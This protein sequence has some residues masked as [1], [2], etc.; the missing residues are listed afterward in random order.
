MKFFGQRQE[1]LRQH[2]DAAAV[3]RE[4]APRR[5]TDLPLGP[6]DVAEVEELQQRKLLG[7]EM[8]LVVE[9]LDLARG[10]MEIDEEAVIAQ[11][12]DAARDGDDILGDGTRRKIAVALLD[13]LG[14]GCPGKHARIGVAAEP[15][16]LLELLEARGAEL[17]VVAFVCHGFPSDTSLT[18]RIY[19]IPG[20]AQRV[21]R[22]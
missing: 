2:G 11:G 16:Q 17:V 1:R 12:A 15:P 3:H 8:V 22:R 13:R 18:Q 14:L 10:V 6:D 7:R 9:D 19:L 5:A 20:E 21:M 4:L